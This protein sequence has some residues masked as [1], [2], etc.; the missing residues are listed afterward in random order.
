MSRFATIPTLQ[1]ASPLASPITEL[2]W[3]T[4]GLGSLVFLLV[5]G[6]TLYFAWRYK[7]RGAGGEPPQIFGNAKDEIIWMGSAAALLVFLFVLAWVMLGRIDPETGQETGQPQVVV[8]GHQWFWEAQYPRAANPGGRD[9]VNV[10]NEIHIPTG[11]KVLVQLESADVIHDFWV[12]RLSRKMDAVPGQPNR[13]WLQADKPGTYLGAC[14][15]FCGAEHAWMRFTVIAQAPQDFQRWLGDQAQQATLSGQGD[16]AQ[17]AAVFAR[18]GCGE[19]HQLRGLGAHGQVGPDLTHFASRTLM[20]G[21]VLST[22]P[23]DVTRWLKNPDAAKPGT[24][25]PNFH[26]SDEQLRQL[27]A[28]LE[29]LK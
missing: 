7:H 12:P 5:T 15:E 10:A 28:F 13:M 8:T 27:T 22:A 17:G 19:C 4:L 25:M 14:A 29:T 11:R 6:L 18:Q 2:I 23:A 21:G 9:V 24:R 3:I 26:L 16:A 20:A 1:P